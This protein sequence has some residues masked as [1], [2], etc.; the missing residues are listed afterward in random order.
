MLVNEPT[1][2]VGAVT[3][4]RL[5]SEDVTG[6]VGRVILVMIVSSKE[7]RSHYLFWY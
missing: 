2:I 5:L 1:A 6:P 4:V 3:G 7:L